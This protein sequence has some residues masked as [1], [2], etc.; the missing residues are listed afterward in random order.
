MGRVLSPA[1]TPSPALRTSLCDDDRTLVNHPI[2]SP[3]NLLPL[4]TWPCGCARGCHSSHTIRR[5]RVRS[6]RYHVA[7]HRGG[8]APR[9]PSRPSLQEGRTELSVPSAFP[10]LSGSCQSYRARM[11]VRYCPAM[12]H[13]DL[14]I[15][16]V[17]SSWAW[18]CLAMTVLTAPC[19]LFL[20]PLLSLIA[21]IVTKN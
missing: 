8:V 19:A 12:L 9:R 21:T 11:H 13:V 18:A 6:S 17:L 16:A 1:S 10:P 4:M 14:D 3:S 2:P 20:L 15:P 7:R 5:D